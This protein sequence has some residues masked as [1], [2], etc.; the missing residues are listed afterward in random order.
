MEMFEDVG[1]VVFCM[2][3]KKWLDITVSHVLIANKYDFFKEQIIRVP[4][5]SAISIQCRRNQS[6]AKPNIL[7]SLC[8]LDMLISVYIAKR[9]KNGSINIIVDH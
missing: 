8:S 2:A 5:G 3:L 1:V 7:L 6:L 9:K 4:L